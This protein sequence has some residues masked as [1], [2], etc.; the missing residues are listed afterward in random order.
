MVKAASI[1][2]DAMIPTNNGDFP[3]FMT[4]LEATAKHG[5]G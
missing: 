1:F 5:Q 3:Y 2:L 4:M